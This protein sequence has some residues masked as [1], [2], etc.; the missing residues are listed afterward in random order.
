MHGGSHLTRLA[1]LW[2]AITGSLS[3][4]AYGQSAS[5]EYG[6]T[7]TPGSVLPRKVV[8]PISVVNR[9]FSQVT[10]EVITGQNLTAVGNPKATRSVIYANSDSSKKVTITVDQYASPT[11][12]SSAYWE[13]VQK[14]KIVPGFKPVSASDLGQ[15]AFI[16]TVTQ[17]DETHIGLGALQGTLIVG[18]TLVGYEPTSDNIA[19]LVSLTREEEAAAKAAL[20][21]KAQD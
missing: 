6:T 1:A 16:G 17:G 5:P 7:S 3:S 15:N 8:I 18:A 4:A 20:D 9:F 10:R 11:D 14:S 2:I 13:A 19:K 21:R 12:A